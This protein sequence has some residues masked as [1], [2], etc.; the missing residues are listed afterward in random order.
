MRSVSI[1]L[2]LGLI[3]IL[4]ACATSRPDKGPRV[5]ANKLTFALPDLAGNTISSSDD[6]FADKVVLV[7]LW[8]SWCPPA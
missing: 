3:V 1:V 7:T 4:G 8:G 5:G 6:R 2:V